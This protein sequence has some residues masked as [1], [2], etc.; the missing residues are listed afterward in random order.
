MDKICSTCCIKKKTTEFH[1][2]KAQK[3]GFANM[4]KACKNGRYNE[5]ARIYNKTRDPVANRERSKKW[6]KDNKGR[7]NAR[8][9]IWRELKGDTFRAQALTWR[10]NRIARIKANGGSHTTKEW[11]TKLN[12]FH[13]KCAICGSTERIERDHIIPVSKGGNN[14]ITNIQPLCLPCNRAKGT[15][16]E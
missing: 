4:C 12:K 16:M 7:Y 8:H 5:Q 13:G 6:Q 9:K 10:L 2:N 3:D 11:L 15:Y 1:K 14:D